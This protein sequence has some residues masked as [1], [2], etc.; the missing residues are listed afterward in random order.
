MS[1]T[2]DIGWLA[3]SATRW[4]ADMAATLEVCPETGILRSVADAGGSYLVSPTVH[5]IDYGRYEATLELG[6]PPAL[7]RAIEALRPLVRAT[8]WDRQ[9]QI[10]QSL[11]S[12][13][14]LPDAGTVLAAADRA[15]RDHPDRAVVLR[16][17]NDRHH[18]ALMEAL[19]ARGFAL[20]PSREVWIHDPRGRP[21]RDLRQDRARLARSGL[22]RGIVGER[23]AEAAL[24]LYEA[25]YHR[26]YTPLNP[27]YTPT[28][29]ARAIRAGTLEVHGLWDGAALVG[30]QAL[31]RAGDELSTPMIGYA[32]GRPGLY[33]LT[34]V[35]AF[36][37]AAAEGRS[38]NL[39]AGVA[40]WKR[41]RGAAPSLERFAIRLPDAAPRRARAALATVAGLARLVAHRRLGA[42]ARET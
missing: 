7:A 34:S 1:A 25:L 14:L 6:V 20:V 42:G 17:L 39:S 28:F 32:P 10:C 13:N 12:T 22:R 37:V 9:V 11:F 4:V 16:S 35:A 33:S 21:T 27:H 29:L 31:H 2:A 5:M 30:M 38:F 3:G 41:N 15:A 23:E 40:G 24:S 19:R 36:D 8:G 18:S 26:R